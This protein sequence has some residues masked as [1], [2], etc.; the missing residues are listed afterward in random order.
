M[1]LFGDRW[2][3]T[4]LHSRCC[5]DSKNSSVSSQNLWMLS[6]DVLV[7]FI[8]PKNTKRCQAT[9]AN[10]STRKN[11]IQLHLITHAF[12][13]SM[14]LLNKLCIPSLNYVYTMKQKVE[15]RR[16]IIDEITK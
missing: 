10:H 5:N 7:S 8:F 16:V 2:S 13:F 1:P 12:R 14:Q 11:N 15:T 6:H 9:F 3:V 4:G